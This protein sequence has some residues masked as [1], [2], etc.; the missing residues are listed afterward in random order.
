[1]IM[2]LAGV[3]ATVAV[4]PTEGCLFRWS[5][6]DR[7]LWE[8]IQESDLIVVGELVD[9][10]V[11]ELGLAIDS[12]AYEASYWL[13]KLGVDLTIP[14]TRPLAAHTLD[15]S[16]TIRGPA[17]RRV[18]FMVRGIESEDTSGLAFPAVY[19]LRREGASWLPARFPIAV[20]GR[21][22]L[23]D[24]RWA[25]ERALAL[26]P[27]A[28]EADVLDWHV[29]A[30]A[31]AGTRLEVVYKLAGTEQPLPESALRRLAEGFVRD[32]GPERTVYDMLELL[33]PY[34]SA[35]VDRAATSALRT[36][37]AGSS[38]RCEAAALLAARGGAA[39]P[40]SPAACACASRP[41]ALSP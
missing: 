7:G 37:T 17:S 22:Q 41:S 1:M 12:F 25:I 39:I 38:A 32:T 26:G 14:T 9:I 11:D 3:L 15:V 28:G 21:R 13:G 27:S 19:F 23:A 10:E 6:P 24:L 4:L 5:W 33:A 18:T 16:A 30:A 29:E 31:S 8:S 34:P 2:I 35:E 36:M 20:S 40:S